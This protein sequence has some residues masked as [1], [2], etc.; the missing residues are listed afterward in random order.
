MSLCLFVIFVTVD[1]KYFE[2][3]N[4]HSIDIPLTLSIT[5]AQYVSIKLWGRPLRNV[6][7]TGYRL[8]RPAICNSTTELFKDKQQAATMSIERRTSDSS[9]TASLSRERYKT[10]HQDTR[11]ISSA[12]STGGG[13]GGSFGDSLTRGVSVLDVYREKLVR[14]KRNYCAGCF[15]LSGY[16]WL[17]LISALLQGWFAHA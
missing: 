13:G 16:S 15:H 4:Q 7:D 5:H 6:S 1:C 8:Y 11:K 3:C 9:S 14:R 17:F 2:F 10:S 12:S